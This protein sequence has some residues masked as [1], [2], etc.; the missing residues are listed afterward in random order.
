MSNKLTCAIRKM[1]DWIA[2]H[3]QTVRDLGT[4]AVNILE[5]DFAVD[6]QNRIQYAWWRI[7]DHATNRISYRV[8][9]CEELRMPFTETKFDSD[10]LNRILNSLYSTNCDVICIFS[11]CHASDLLVTQLYGLAFECTNLDEAVK[12]VRDSQKVMRSILETYYNARLEKP[13]IQL[14][15]T[16]KNQLGSLPQMLYLNGYP[17]SQ[18]PYG[19]R[20]I[21]RTELL[22]GLANSGTP[23]LF[24][25]QAHPIHREKLI[26]IQTQLDRK[27]SNYAS[28]QHG[29]FNFSVS[30]DSD[31]PPSISQIW[32]T[33]ND[34]A[35]RLTNQTRDLANIVSSAVQSGGWLTSAWLLVEDNNVVTAKDLAN[36]AFYNPSTLMPYPVVA[37]ELLEAE[38]RALQSL[39]M[40]LRGDHEFVADLDLATFKDTQAPGNRYATLLPSSMLGVY[41]AP[42]QLTGR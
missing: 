27:A 26:E 3:P 20:T 23:F 36:R 21:P 7:Y 31:S 6:D 1:L 40:A 28:R 4:A 25:V 17:N 2:G 41:W 16:I 37:H 15:Q 18:P 5:E 22:R 10:F 34:V 38:R 42:Y 30:P 29:D 35:I 12:E 24:T 13:T 11:R 39:L 14:W 32:Q 33:E 19:A 8:L 9:I